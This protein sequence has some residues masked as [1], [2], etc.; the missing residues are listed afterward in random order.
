[1]AHPR[2]TEHLFSKSAFVVPIPFFQRVAFWNPTE[3][4]RASPQRNDWNTTVEGVLKVLQRVI[5]PAT[6]AQQHHNGICGI[7]RVGICQ[8]GLVVRIDHA[9]GA[10]RK[11]HGAFETMSLRKK[12]P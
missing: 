5:V 10:Y 6:K 12:F 7:Q 8:A 3:S 4:V 9:T 1:M 11:Q 2:F